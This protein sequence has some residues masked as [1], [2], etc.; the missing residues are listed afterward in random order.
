MDSKLNP[1]VTA[2]LLAIAILAIGVWAWGDSAAKALGGPGRLLLGPQGHLYVAIQDRLLEH[3]AEGSFLKTH[4]LGTLG[5]DGLIGDLAFFADGDLLLRLGSDPSTL[6]DRVRSFVRATDTRALAPAAPG[7]GLHRCDLERAQCRPFGDPALDFKA[8][9]GLAID[10]FDGTVYVADTTRHLLRKFSAEGTPLAAPAGGVR[11]PNQ[12]LLHH[13]RLLVAD[14]NRH[15][16]LV[17]DAATD[18]FGTQLDAIDVVPGDAQRAGH[19]WP[20][21]LARVGGA[22]WVVNMRR[23]LGAGGVYVFDDNWRYLRR[24]E[25]PDGADPVAIVAFR[26]EALIGDWRLGRIHRIPD[27]GEP[28]G[29]FESVGLVDLY[30]ALDERRAHYRLVSHLGVGLLVALLVAMLLKGLSAPASVSPGNAAGGG[31]APRSPG[32]EETIWLAP[33]AARVRKLRAALWVVG[34]LFAAV[35]ALLAWIATWAGGAA[36]VSGI[37]APVL[38]LFVIYLLVAWVTRVNTRTAIGLRGGLVTLRDH[39]GRETTHPLSQAMFDGTTLAT[40]DM[41][42]FL[43]QP[44]SSLYDRQEVMRHLYPR[45]GA[46]RAISVIAMLQHMVRLRHPQGLILVLLLFALIAG[47]AAL[48]LGAFG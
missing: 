42:V 2:L 29:V 31:V 32:G 46:A 36:F 28:A 25:L 41:A 4:D 10:P 18:R 8:T 43:G 23:D 40:P 37:V 39:T 30:A 7:A 5:V 20:T 17:A 48:M 47:L 12:L 33:D 3:D 45:L 34:G 27:R 21:R 19:T 13:G 11:F 24:V 1:L 38:G 22:W 44:A 6:R 26:G 15:R 16:V 14:T 9:F 35:C